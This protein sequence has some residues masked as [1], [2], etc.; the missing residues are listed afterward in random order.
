MKLTDG[1][2]TRRTEHRGALLLETAGALILLA[3]I[4]TL[5]V[6][7]LRGAN[8]QRQTTDYRIWALTE[9]QNTLDRVTG[10]PWES[11][12]EKTLAPLKLDEATASRLP[13]GRLTVAVADAQGQP[14]AKRLTVEIRWKNR[15][16]TDDA[17]VRLT[18]WVYQKGGR[19]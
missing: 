10:L 4:M 6:Q 11:L 15:T 14:A 7:L 19:P 8:L 1:F 12:D 2:N 5:T 9:A 17:P 16:G 18:T 13:S 3:I